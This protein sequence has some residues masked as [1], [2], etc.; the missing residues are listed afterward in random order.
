MDWESQKRRM[1]ASLEDSGDGGDE[2]SERERT[3]IASTI[4]ITDA[5]IAEKD[6]EIS[7]LK[8]Q[9]AACAEASNTPSDDR[10]QA[11]NALLDA[12]EIIQHHR[13]KIAQ[14]EQETD[15][16]LRAAELEISVERAKIARQKVE[17]DQL[18]AE[19]E[20]ERYALGVGA[21]QATPA[22]GPK[23][24]WLSKLGLGSEEGE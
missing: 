19:L 6:Q 20:A 5:V 17:L 8:A 24:R 11:V 13:Q 12:D 15:D 2:E 16:K 22:G 3:T 23:R 7:E 21:G 9:L 10:D 4:E 18:Q 1:L 14:L